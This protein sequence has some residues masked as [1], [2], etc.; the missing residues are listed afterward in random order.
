MMLKKRKEEEKREKA[1]SELQ[2][3]WRT[4]ERQHY[5]AI[6]CNDSGLEVQAGGVETNL[7]TFRFG[8]KNVQNPSD[9]TRLT[10]R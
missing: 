6:D 7:Y 5:E 10:I 8:V 4:C 3:L 9:Y 1:I 2:E